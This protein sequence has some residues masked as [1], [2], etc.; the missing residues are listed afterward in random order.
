MSTSSSSLSV[1]WRPPP[2][3]TLNGEFLGYALAYRAVVAGGAEPAGGGPGVAGTVDINEDVLRVQV[4]EKNQRHVSEKIIDG[5]SV[6]RR[7]VS[8]I[9]VHPMEQFV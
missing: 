5:V 1:V 7:G 3:N 2:A 8:L 9:L 6:H 4:S